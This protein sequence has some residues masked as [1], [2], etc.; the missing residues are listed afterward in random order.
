[1]MVTVTKK[2]KVTKKY[3]TKRILKFSDYRDCLLNNEIILKLQERF[4]IEAHNVYPGEVNKTA[5]S[6]NY[7]K[8][9]QTF[10]RIVSYP[11]G[12][13]T[14]KESKT[15]LIKYLNTIYWLW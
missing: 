1:M 7:D 3:V 8:I 5:L 14:G 4:K 13:N 12:R 11:Y 6:S 15:E 2:A 9:F 10:V